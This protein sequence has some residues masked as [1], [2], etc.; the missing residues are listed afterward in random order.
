[1]AEGIPES[2]RDEFI[3]AFKRFDRDKDGI[4]TV[5]DLEHVMIAAGQ[6]PRLGELEDMIAEVGTSEKVTED[7]FVALMSRI[8]KDT[9]QEEQL[10]ETFKIFDKDGN[11]Q[12]SREE[13]REALQVLLGELVNDEELDEMIKEGDNDGDGMI[14]YEEFVKLMLLSK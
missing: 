9:D 14:N 3:E 4:I 1:M 10:A 7:E 11:G 6:N 8:S 13:L 12:I 5:K 2:K